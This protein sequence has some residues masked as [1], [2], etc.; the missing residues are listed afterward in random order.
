MVNRSA[1][2]H[3]RFFLVQKPFRRQ[4]S[5]HRPRVL[6]WPRIKLIAREVAN[7]K[8]SSNHCG[9]NL[10]ITLSPTRPFYCERSDLAD[11]MREETTPCPASPRFRSAGRMH[12]HD[13]KGHRADP[14]GCRRGASERRYEKNSR[15][16][17]RT[18]RTLIRSKL[19][20]ALS[21][22]ARTPPRGAHAGLACQSHRPKDTLEMAR[23]HAPSLSPRH[24]MYPDSKR[25]S[26]TRIRNKTEKRETKDQAHCDTR[27]AKEA[28]PRT[29]QIKATTSLSRPL[30]ASLTTRGR[31]Q[32]RPTRMTHG[33]M[34]PKSFL[35]RL[36]VGASSEGGLSTTRLRHFAFAWTSVP[37]NGLDCRVHR[38]IARRDRRRNNRKVA[39]RELDQ[40][41]TDGETR[42]GHHLLAWVAR[43][44]T[45]RKMQM[46]DV[47]SEI[48]RAQ[49]ILLC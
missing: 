43:I 27:A 41:I 4:N 40:R 9:T 44:W 33:A 37:R 35:A 3:K 28:H 25:R 19:M 32:Q 45:K 1:A 7:A 21:T 6:S 31:D 23:M 13:L 2:G 11:C 29:A 15:M 30:Y 48:C 39:K 16:E 22:N 8:P 14:T 26:N 5:R 12:R 36:T 46:C 38:V 34:H 47:P 17:K 10:V 42:Q 20:R 24:A 49:R 18:V